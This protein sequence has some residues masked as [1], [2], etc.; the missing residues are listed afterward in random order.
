M[1]EFIP[2]A[3]GSTT[4]QGISGISGKS[5]ITKSPS[6]FLSYFAWVQ[7]RYLN[8]GHIFID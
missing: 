2:G 5:W 4:I 1:S 6:D 3:N 8:L 7:F